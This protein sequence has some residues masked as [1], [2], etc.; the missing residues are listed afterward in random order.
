MSREIIQSFYDHPSTLYIATIG[1]IC[2]MTAGGV[3]YA[4]TTSR[5]EYNEKAYPKIET[6]I[7]FVYGTTK[8]IS[9]VA[10][11]GCVGFCTAMTFPVSLPLYVMYCD[12]AEDKKIRD[13]MKDNNLV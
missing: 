5:F 12:N 2:G 4:A 10:I 11:G 1:T 13:K 7:Q 8:C 6:P 3:N 9:Y